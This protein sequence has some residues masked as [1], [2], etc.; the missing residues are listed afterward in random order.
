MRDFDVWDTLM[1]NYVWWNTCRGFDL[2]SRAV[3][4]ARE[5]MWYGVN[6]M[7]SKQGIQEQ[8]FIT[9]KD[10]SSKWKSR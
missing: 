6:P 7:L 1:N 9:S 2:Y 3:F 8:L 5:Q 4:P 10:F